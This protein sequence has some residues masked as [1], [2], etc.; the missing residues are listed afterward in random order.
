DDVKDVERKKP[1]FQA[2]KIPPDAY[3]VLFFEKPSDLKTKLV[4]S[5]AKKDGADEA[6]AKYD[7]QWA[8][9]SEETAA[10]DND[11]SRP[12]R[13]DQNE[14]VVQYEVKFANGIDCGGAYLK[15]ISD[16]PHLDLNNFNDKTPYTIM[17]GPDKCGL[18]H[19]FHFIIRYKN[20]KTGEIEEKHAKKVTSDIDRYFSDKRTH[21]YTL[22]LRSDNT[23]ERYIDQVKVQS[24]SLLKDME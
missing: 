6:I 17:F 3:L 5:L 24:G 8:V 7:G 19:K 9:E 21:L 14:L 22:V 16:S 11:Y 13:F 18:D 15:L 2:P 20:P 4:S 12:I 10:L 1:L 23:F